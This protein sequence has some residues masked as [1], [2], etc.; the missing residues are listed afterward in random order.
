MFSNVATPPKVHNFMVPGKKPQPRLGVSFISTIGDYSTTAESAVKTSTSSPDGSTAFSTSQ[1]TSETKSDEAVS[2]ST[3]GVVSTDNSVGS[4]SMNP[5]STA[6]TE[7]SSIS[8][9]QT[10]G[11]DD[12]STVAL[13]EGND[14]M[15]TGDSFSTDN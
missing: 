11:T 13:T 5:V 2:K 4:S 3:T 1:A 15:S 8:E 12:T 6:L 9:I 10:S 14:I 7:P